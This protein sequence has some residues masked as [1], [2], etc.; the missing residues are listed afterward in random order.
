M[1]RVCLGSPDAKNDTVL[2]G[3]S[4]IDG[5]DET[6]APGSVVCPKAPSISSLEVWLRMMPQYSIQIVCTGSAE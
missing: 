1:S 2:R 6:H 4:N 3:S 5:R